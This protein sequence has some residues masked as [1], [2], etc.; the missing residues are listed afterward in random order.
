MDRNKVKSRSA[1][2]AEESGEEQGTVGEGKV[3]S[4]NIMGRGEAAEHS[5]NE[6]GSE[7]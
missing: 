3:C 4:N 6:S 1:L 5:V 2:W 7:Y